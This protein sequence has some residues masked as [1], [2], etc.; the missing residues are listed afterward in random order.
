LTPGVNFIRELFKHDKTEKILGT[1]RIN[2]P[3]TFFDEIYYVYN[4]PNNLNVLKMEKKTSRDRNI[5][6]KIEKMEKELY[7]KQDFKDTDPFIII[8][9]NETEYENNVVVE[10]YLSSQQIMGKDLSRGITQRYIRSKGRNRELE[11]VN[12]P[13]I[14]VSR[15]TTSFNLNQI[16]C[17]PAQIT[18]ESERSKQVQSIGGNNESISE[19]GSILIKEHNQNLLMTAISNVPTLKENQNNLHNNRPTSTSKP[20]EK[21]SYTKPSVV[22][23]EYKT[24]FNPSK[25]PNIAYYMINR[26]YVE[27][28]VIKKGITP[29]KY[30]K[31]CTIQSTKK[32]SFDIVVMSGEAIRPYEYYANEL[33]IFIKKI[34]NFTLKTIV[35][36]FIKDEKGV[37][38]FLGVKSFTPYKEFQDPSLNF[39]T[40][41]YL[42]EEKNIKKVY[43]TLTCK[44]CNLAYPKS[45]INKVVTFKLLLDLKENQAKRGE[46]IF[47]HITRGN[48]NESLSC[49]V[50]NLCY[51]LIITEQELIEVNFY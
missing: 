20:H 26:E 17:K 40:Q 13:K 7:H 22:R 27:P 16:H 46:N 24:R 35:I 23:L 3:D 25:R 19:S 1:L 38:Y 14:E 12:K 8:R 33:V 43:K 2:I 21:K 6:E 4:D 28:K 11:G 31:I 41:E 44:L 45:K 18:E 29:E 39:N 42:K 10:S 50:C 48:S 30:T 15:P 36:D 9:Q 37:I 34:F 49:Q 5:F 51:K 47:K 32:N